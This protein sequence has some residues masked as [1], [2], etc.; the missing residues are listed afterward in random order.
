MKVSRVFLSSC[1]VLAVAVV[2][3]AADRPQTSV[4]GVNRS[5]YR[6]PGG[7]VLV[8][9]TTTQSGA[10]WASQDFEAA[11]NAYD[12]QG[13]DD[14][15]IPAGPNWSINEVVAPGFNQGVPVPAMNI[16]FF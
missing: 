1:A 5:P 6:S 13:A 15:T 8:D 12:C 10:G 16:Q 4:K 3:S 7:A 11:F 2:A 14:F 9:Q